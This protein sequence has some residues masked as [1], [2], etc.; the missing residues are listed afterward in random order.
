MLAPPKA[1]LHHMKSFSH[2]KGNKFFFFFTFLAVVLTTT[3]DC[4]LRRETVPHVRTL[5]LLSGDAV[6]FLA[7]VKKQLQNCVLSLRTFIFF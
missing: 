5:P 2:T 3:A 7:I 1:V 6:H 4:T